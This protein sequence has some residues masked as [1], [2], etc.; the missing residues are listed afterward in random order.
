MT[1]TKV[2]L[3]R[4]KPFNVTQTE[5][6]KTSFVIVKTIWKTALAD[7]CFGRGNGTYRSKAN[8]NVCLIK[9]RVTLCVSPVPSIIYFTFST[10]PTSLSKSKHKKKWQRRHKSVYLTK[11]LTRLI[12]YFLGFQRT[13]VE[14]CT[15]V[16]LCWSPSP[17]VIAASSVASWSSVIWATNCHLAVDVHIIVSFFEAKSGKIEKLLGTFFVPVIQGVI[18]GA[19]ED[20]KIAVK[21]FIHFPRSV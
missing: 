19:T 14:L 17:P 8:R 11:V 6:N 7:V 9:T 21:S 10:L 5:P 15:H 2:A 1:T 18:P 16:L 13:N 3:I 20:K 12:R 4:R